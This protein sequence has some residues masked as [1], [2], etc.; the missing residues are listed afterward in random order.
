LQ[1][2]VP[3]GAS[4][5]G[6]AERPRRQSATRCVHLQPRDLRSLTECLSCCTRRRCPTRIRTSQQARKRLNTADC[7]RQA[8]RHSRQCTFISAERQPVCRC[9]MSGVGTLHAAH[10]AATPRF[11]APSSFHVNRG[12]SDVQEPN[13]S[14]LED[15]ADSESADSLRPEEWSIT[16]SE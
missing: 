4:N 13:V 16:S 11:H 12:A 2:Q 9:G 3:R 1:D 8:D 14:G 10:L 6:P 5:Q 7:T 15:A